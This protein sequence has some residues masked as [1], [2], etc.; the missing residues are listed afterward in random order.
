MSFLKSPVRFV[1]FRI[2]NCCII[3]FI[4]YIA[5]S[6]TLIYYFIIVGGFVMERKGVVMK[7]ASFP[8]S[9]NERLQSV[10]DFLG[11]VSDSDVI[12]MG[13]SEL[14]RKVEREMDVDGHK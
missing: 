10:R 12:R 2:N 6:H 3:I 13:V 14:C 7:S 9:L 5:I 1:Y 4:Y 8:I 11:L